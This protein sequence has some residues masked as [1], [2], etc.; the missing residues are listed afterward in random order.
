[1]K[2]YIYT[3]ILLFFIGSNVFGQAPSWS[4]DENNFQYTMSFVS[5]LN[6]EGTTLSSEN[7]KVAAFVD[8]E[9]RG[10]T[11]LVYVQS[12]NRYYAYL[13]VFSN[14]GNET[15]DFKAYD[16]ANDNLV[17]IDKTIA[18]EINAHYG[19][20]LQAYSLANPALNNKAEI[21]DLTFKDVP[22]SNQ[23][24]SGKERILSVYDGL[25]LTNLNA[26]FELSTGAQLFFEGAKVV[27]GNNALDLSVPVAL[28]VLSEDESSLETWT[29]SVVYDAPIGNLLFYKKNA[30]CYQGGV[31]KVVSSES[32][33]GTT[34]S[35]FKNQ[36][37]HTIQTLTDGETIFSNLEVGDY[38]VKI[39]NIEKA[40][41][42]NLKE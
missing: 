40:I 34:V 1:M 11:N 28:Q 3:L 12:K 26:I 10:V 17:D 4:V 21:L 41:R 39:N 37:I 15:I 7:D 25:E 20:L 6:L 31:I 29:I 30:V 8:G 35:L 14:T 36:S 9:C 23:T 13:V 19:D 2:N 16:A 27:S 38:T 22:I 32:V 33:T 42:V 18:F 5:F 24:I